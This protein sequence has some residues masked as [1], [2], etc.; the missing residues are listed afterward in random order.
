MKTIK[1]FSYLFTV[2]LATVIGF[3]SCSSDDDNGTDVNPTGKTKEVSLSISIGSNT[4][5]RADGP[6]AVGLTP[7]V[8][9]LTLYFYDG[10]GNI[11][12]TQQFP[13]SGSLPAGT[14]MKTF[15]VPAAATKIY[16]IGNTGAISGSITFASPLAN[17]TDLKS[18]FIHIDKQTH[19]QNAVNVKGEATI[20]AGTPSSASIELRAVVARIE[21]KEIKSALETNVVATPLTSFKV[22]NIF[23]NNTYMKFPLN[24]TL[25]S[26]GLVAADILNFDKSVWGSPFPAIYSAAGAIYRDD[27]SAATAG[28][29]HTP[30]GAVWGY[31][32]PATT[33]AA[34]GT[35]F[36]DPTDDGSGAVKQQNVPHI[37]LE[38]TDATATGM[39]IPA[40]Q[41]VTV[42][43][44]KKASDGSSVANLAGGYYYIINSLNIG[45]EH[46]TTASED[47]KVELEVTVEVKPWEEVEVLP[48]I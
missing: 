47:P 15:T 20:T 48:E 21:V 25:P 12:S 5:L 7:D 6:S 41:Y 28:T 13:I 31:F 44:L 33:G 42:K 23:I 3:A 19:P 46:L 43:G 35:T 4:Q 1:K 24:E 39:V 38:I 17:I 16:A 22:T 37:I 36:P 8:A 45:A 26:S 11:L 30:S 32:V 40:K 2:A 34:N 10:T 18:S 27:N 29:S 9:D 14:T